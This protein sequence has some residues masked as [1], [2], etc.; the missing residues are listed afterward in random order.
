MKHIMSTDMGVALDVL[1]VLE[2]ESRQS[3]EMIK[4]KIP[5]YTIHYIKSALTYLTEMSHVNRVVRGLYEITE[6]GKYV[7]HHPLNVQDLGD[8]QKLGGSRE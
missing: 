5:Q 4:E 3:P 2:E 7:L 1:R 6:L 8:S